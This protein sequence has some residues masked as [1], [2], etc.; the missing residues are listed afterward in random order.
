MPLIDDA[1]EASDELAAGL[2]ERYLATAAGM[3]VEQSGQSQPVWACPVSEFELWLGALESMLDMPLGRRL[4]HAAAESEEWRMQAADRQPPNPLFGKEKKRLAWLNEDWH[5]RG[6]GELSLLESDSGEV[7]LVVRRRPHPALAAGIT[8]AAWER[9]QKQR[10]RFRWSDGGSGESLITLELDRREIPSSA[11][12]TP[13]WD[14]VAASST[15]ATGSHPFLLSY[16]DGG[17]WTVDGVRMLALAQDLLLRFEDV[18]L[19]HLADKERSSDPRVGWTGVDDRDRLLFWDALAEVGR[20]K[21]VASGEMVLVAAPTDW[22]DV[23]RRF[24]S[25]SG[26]G[27]ITTAESLDDM[28]GVRLTADK[29]FHPALAIGILLGAWER[30]EARPA[31]AAWTSSEDGHTIELTSLRDIA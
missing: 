27:T 29:L 2:Q 25:T 15:V 3:L 7:S 26:M 21:F 11:A 23:G 13:S 24:L 14:E 5:Q 17:N 12:I 6:M 28:G 9:L 22:V 20:A 30:A 10:Y 19:P 18:V 8:C 31:G 4:A 1:V 16:N